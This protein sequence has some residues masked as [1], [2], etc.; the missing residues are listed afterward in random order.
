MSRRLGLLGP[1]RFDPT[2]AAAV[3][4]AGH[5]GPAGDRHR[6]LAGAR[7]RDRRA[8]RAP[9]RPRR[10][11]RAAPPRRRRLRPRP[12][13]RRGAPRAPG[14]VPRACRSSTSTASTSL[15]RVCRELFSRAR[16]RSGDRARSAATRSTPCARLD[17]RHLGAHASRS[18]RRSHERWRPL[19]R[20][21]VA[22]RP[23]RDRA[24][25]RPASRAWRSPAGTSPALLNRLRLFGVGR[26]DRRASR[27]FA[28]SGGAMVCGERIVLFHD[29]PPQGRGNAEVLDAG[30]GLVP[31]MV[32]LPHAR[33][34][35]RPRRPASR[36]QLLA[37][38]FA[39][40]RCVAARRRRAARSRTGAA[41]AA[42]R[43]RPASLDRRHGHLRAAATGP[44]RERRTSPRHPPRSRTR[45]RSTPARSIASSRPTRSRSSRGRASRSSGA[46]RPTPCTCG[47][48]STACRRRSRSRACRHRP[49]V[50]RARAAAAARASSTSSRSC[51]AGSGELD[52]GPAQPAS[53]RATR[54]ARTRSCHAPGY[55]DPRVDAAR[56]RGAP[57]HARGA[58]AARATRSGRDAR[59]T[60]YLPARFR[61]HAPLPAARR[62]RR[63][64]LPARTPGSR[65][66]STT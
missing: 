33:R 62:P 21:A 66:C 58:R 1:Q 34:R 60:L 27:S 36:L 31:G 37:R 30:L 18:T 23:R 40:A 65:P 5:R 2:L 17:A 25:A 22:R 59:V 28:W 14:A 19:E 39:P 54:S 3:P 24:A 55:D 45:R 51:A 57:G 6:R 16:G 29:R 64:R 20:E 63:R 32:L 52:P 53:T 15:K 43:G 35:L 8:A 11:P 42:R 44:R 48:S 41:G 12:R 61:A 4:V 26:A 7:G 47:T 10:E 49:V 46:A 13:A 50:P 9:R 38:R 56:P